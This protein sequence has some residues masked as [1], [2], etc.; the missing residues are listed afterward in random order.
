M[1]EYSIIKIYTSERVRYEG[2]AVAQAVQEYIRSLKIASRCVILRGIGGCSEN[3]SSASSAIVDLSY[4]LPLIIEIILPSAD[5]DVVLERLDAMVLDGIVTVV[6][7]SVVSHKTA[8][9]LV[10]H[11]LRIRD[12]MTTSPICAHDDFSVRSAVE[13]ML[14]K[15]LKC[16]PVVDSENHCIGIITQSDLLSRAKMPL[17]LGLLPSM[18][19]PERDE[20]LYSCE[21][22][23]CEDIMSRRPTVI[24]ADAKLEDAIRIMNKDGRKRLPVVDDKTRIVGMLSRI[25]ILRAIA[26]AGSPHDSVETERGSAAFSPYVE[27]INDRD[28]LSIPASTGL[29]AAIDTLI[30]KG[31][32]RAAVVDAEG[33]LIG[34]ITDKTLLQALGGQVRGLWPF[35]FGGRARRAARPISEIMERSLIT[36]TENMSIYEVL[37]LMTEHGLKRVP[38]VDSKGVF[39]GMIRRDS[40]L[41]AFSRLWGSADSAR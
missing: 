23:R 5:K 16:L 4:D 29:K 14:D 31:E 30:A 21:S 11:N 6:D 12:V 41:L 34:I 7:A 37:R 20:W 32:Q 17:R 19:A 18:P 28:R 40:I 35:G 22:F 3:G 15:G 2:K 27:G 13:L 33:R 1:N 9:S 26:A 25:D 24:K 10:P 8:A 39:T 38:V 36:A